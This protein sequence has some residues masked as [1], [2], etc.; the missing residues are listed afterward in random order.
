MAGLKLP[1]YGKILLWF[2]VNLFVLAG[3]GVW[4]MAAQ[5]RLGLDWMLAGPGG[6]RLEQLGATLTADLR[7]HPESEWAETLL[8]HERD[9]GLTLSLFGSDGLQKTGTPVDVPSEV[10]SKLIDK[11]R[12]EEMPPPPR[13]RKGDAKNNAKIREPRPPNDSPPKPRFMMRTAEPTTYWAGLHLALAY[14]EGASRRPLTLLLVS[15][16]ITGRGFFFNPWPWAGL[17]AG[18]LLISALIWLPVV[19][20]ITRAI[21]RTNDASKRIAAGGFE[22]RVPDERGDELGELA[23][24]VNTMAAQLGDYVAQQRRITADVAHELCSPI[25][26]M[27]MALGVVEQRGTPEQAG[28]LKKIDAELQHMA[29]LVEEVLAFSKAQTLPEREEPKTFRLQSLVDQ[30]VTRE[31]PD[32]K[33]QLNIDDLE[34]HMLRSALDRALGNVLR[35]AVRYASDIE[36]R[37]KPQDGG[38]LIQIMDRGPGVPADSLPRLFEPFFRPEAAR[39]RNTGGSGLGLAI[40]KRSVEGCGGSVTAANREGG[41]FVVEIKVAR[42]FAA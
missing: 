3:L 38:A 4:F 22:V 20:G 27:Q 40:T 13:P 36:I 7:Q 14:G 5:F 15:D 16:S 6:E 12:A 19:G 41:G 23:H 1:L 35:N 17:A 39:S 9:L 24:A 11:R 2:L 18:G 26:R 30:V 25:A 31:A 8:Q 29:R 28:Y 32:M 33:I 10:L 42:H 34:L 37:A 21:R